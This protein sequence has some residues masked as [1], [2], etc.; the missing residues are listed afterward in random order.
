MEVPLL[1]LPMAPA[2][3]IPANWSGRPNMPIMA[4]DPAEDPV[5]SALPDLYAL[6]PMEQFP[7][8]ALRVARQVIGGDKGE[9]TEVDLA[10]GDFRV[11]V[12]PEPAELHDLR[13]ARRA[14][15][16]EHPVMAHFLRSD[17]PES[18]LISDFVEPAAF[19]RLGLYGEFFRCLGVEDQL[20]VTVSTCASG[21][22]AGISI[23]RGTPGFDDWDRL[24]LNRLR[25]HLMIARENAIQFSK[26]LAGRPA[27][28]SDSNALDRLTGRQREILNQLA[29][30]LT[31]AQIAVAL[32]ISPDTVRKHVENILLRLGLPTRTAAAVFYIT[33]SIPAEI[34]PWTAFVPSMHPGFGVTD[35]FVSTQAA[36][37]QAASTQI[38]STGAA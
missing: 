19:H 8:H 6:T 9:Y 15:M 24:L 35:P 18:R 28:Q 30:G 25:P 2:P 12:D 17:A 36:S 10:T 38:T 5:V 14:Y 29:R 34:A 32:E 3:T 7:A 4:G 16:H 22:P 37:T 23:D 1:S 20:S 31:N 11:L 26:A 21:H 33:R 13:E 27:E